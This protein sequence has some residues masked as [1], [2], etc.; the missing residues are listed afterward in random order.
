MAKRRTKADV[1][2]INED[3]SWVSAKDGQTY[4]FTPKEKLFADT[5]LTNGGNGAQAAMATFQCKSALVGSAIAYEY[6]RKPH[7]TAYIQSHYEEHGFNLDD[8]T[9]EHLFLLN[10]HADL[11][12]KTKAVELFYRLRGKLQDKDTGDKTLI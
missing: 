1:V 2:T 8:V 12:S 7:I 5:Y 11:K 10:Q 9:K 6:L 3:F 4:S